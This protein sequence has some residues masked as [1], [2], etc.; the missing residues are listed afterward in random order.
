MFRKFIYGN[1]LCSEMWSC[2]S[3]PVFKKSRRFIYADESCIALAHFNYRNDCLDCHFVLRSSNVRD[4]LYY[5]LN[6]LYSLCKEVYYTLELESK[7]YCRL[8]FTINSAHIPVIMTD[9]DEENE[10]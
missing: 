9:E 3:L 5:D 4:T 8:R 6:F 10:S 2:F 1:T 7:V